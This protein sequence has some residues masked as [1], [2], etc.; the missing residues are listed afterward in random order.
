MPGRDRCT[1]GLPVEAS[2]DERVG[3]KAVLSLVFGILGFEVCPCIG[4]VLAILL[5]WGERSGVGRAGFLLG[6]ISVALYALV[7]V[8]VA[9]FLVL[10]A[11]A[12]AL[13]V[14]LD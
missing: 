12:S 14:A 10:A 1:V 9:F 7:G 8:A 11:I 13:G 5:G 6:W 4:G 3:T 2:M